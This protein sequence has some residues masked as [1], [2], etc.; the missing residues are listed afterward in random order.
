MAGYARLASLMGTYPEVAIFRRFG[1]LNVQNLLYLQA[2]ITIL[3]NELRRTENAD[4]ESA[5]QDRAIYGRDWQ[6]LSDSIDGSGDGSQ[7]RT[8]LKNRERLKEYSE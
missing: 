4:L 8:F 1:A 7:W 5:D 3:E 2:E 6:T